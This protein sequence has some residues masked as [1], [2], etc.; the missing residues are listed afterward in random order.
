MGQYQRKDRFYRKAKEQ[1]LPSRASFKIEEIIQKFSFVSKGQR[2]LDLGAAPGGWTAILAQ[3]VGPKGLIL[4]TD[5]LPLQ[6]VAGSNI[7]FYQGDIFGEETRLWLEEKL[8]GKKI[9][10]LCSDLSPNLSGIYFKDAL[11]SVELA[12][13]SLELAARFLKPGGNWVAKVF[14]G[15]EFPE[16]IKEVK[17]R[18]KRHKVFEPQSTRKTSKEVYVLGL[19]FK[20][21]PSQPPPPKG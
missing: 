10:A 21:P 1:G 18:F 13:K 5:R 17:S 14:P 15:E 4:A 3:A 12:Q 8:K 20:P 7:E 6:G 9:D 2:V 11:A 16:L 19:Q